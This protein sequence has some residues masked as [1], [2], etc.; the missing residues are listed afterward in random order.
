[1]TASETRHGVM[2]DGMVVVPNV[3]GLAQYNA[4]ALKLVRQGPSQTVPVVNRRF[5][6]SKAYV[7]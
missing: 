5:F 1:M 4:L 2:D 6:S 3:N 7:A